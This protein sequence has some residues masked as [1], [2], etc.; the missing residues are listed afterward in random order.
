MQDS[1]AVHQTMFTVREGE[2]LFEKDIRAVVQ[3]ALPDA[4]S[5]DELLE[6]TTHDPE[7]KELKSAIAKGYLTSPER[8]ALG[9]QFDP[10]L[11]LAVLGGLVVRG[12]RIVVPRS[13]RD[14][15]VRLAH[16]GH[17]G[18][19][20][21]TNISGPGSGFQI[22]TGWWKPIFSTASHVR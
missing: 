9:P 12:S 8:Q 6:E 10:V 17:Q 3:A 22:W 14:K 20:K 19:Q 15:V 11:E 1:K 5:W 21:Q 7:L 16:E 4:V 18:L 2:E 13:L